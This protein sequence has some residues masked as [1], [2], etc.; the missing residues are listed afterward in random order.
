MKD[1]IKAKPNAGLQIQKTIQWLKAIRADV[2]NLDDAGEAL[3]RLKEVEIIE[4]VAY[5]MEIDEIFKEAA[6]AILALQ[7]RTGK[8][9][10]PAPKRG[11]SHPKKAIPGPGLTLEDFKRMGIS[12]QNASRYRELA[13]MPQFVFDYGLKSASKPSLNS[14]LSEYGR[15]LKLKTAVD[16]ADLK[17]GRARLRGFVEGG[18][19]PIQAE[20]DL[21]PDDE[22]EVDI[23]D[24]GDEKG[25]EEEETEDFDAFLDD[26]EGFAANAE[27][28]SK[29]V[30]EIEKVFKNITSI[31]KKTFDIGVVALKKMR[32]SVKKLTELFKDVKGVV[33]D[34]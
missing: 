20:A 28:L 15:Y 18:F 7:R 34:D 13:A 27:S 19:T 21:H 25:E 8:L 16:A 5:K 29:I 17:D 3:K 14:E 6:Y 23:F 9:F 2:E 24:F 31:K 30:L 4:A 12:T 22:D 33:E 1:L 26:M 11:G 32:V 10:G